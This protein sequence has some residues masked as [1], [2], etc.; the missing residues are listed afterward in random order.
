MLRLILAL[1]SLLAL[2]SQAGLAQDAEARRVVERFEQLKP[3]ED[4]LAMYRLDWESSLADAQRRAKREKRP[5]CLVIIHARY[6]DITS[7]HC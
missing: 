3:G 7:G 2:M 6:G 4:D 5:V 1:V